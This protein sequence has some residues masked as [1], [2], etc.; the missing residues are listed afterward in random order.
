MLSLLLLLQPGSTPEAV[1]P[2]LPHRRMRKRIVMYSSEWHAISEQISKCLG[3]RSHVTTSPQHN[4]KPGA[5]SPSTLTCCFKFP[6]Q[7][8]VGSMRVTWPDDE[9]TCDSGD[10][11]CTTVKLFSGYWF[12]SAV[13]ICIGLSLTPAE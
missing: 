9:K 10:T 13:K 2:V 3:Q 11:W 6:F 8:I 12:D 4:V 1:C 5:T 7:P